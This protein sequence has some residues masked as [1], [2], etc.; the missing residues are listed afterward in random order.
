MVIFFTCLYFTGFDPR[1]LGSVNES[2]LTYPLDHDAPK[3]T[4]L[5][6]KVPQMG[7]ILNLHCVGNYVHSVGNFQIQADG[8]AGQGAWS[9]QSRQQV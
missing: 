7:K 1:S 5:C 3:V 6:F 8:E 9:E 4:Q 2:Q